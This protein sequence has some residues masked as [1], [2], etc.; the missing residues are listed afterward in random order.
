LP[1]RAQPKSGDP[2]R[3]IRALP[4]AS[5]TGASGNASTALMGFEGTVPGAV[6]RIKRGEELRARLVNGLAE[7]T[8]I[9]W[10]GVRVP[11]G[12]DGVPPLTQQPVEP[13]ASFDYTFRPRDAG[14]FWYRAHSL[15]QVGR[16]LYGALIIEES[17]N[18]DVDRDLVLVLGEPIATQS[19][20]K[21]PVLVNGSVSPEMAVQV[22]DRLRLRLINAAVARGFALKLQ[23]LIP[24]VAAIDGQPV[25]PFLPH[26]GRVV[27]A[28]GGR[29]DLF[30]DIAG[31][32]GAALMLAG[33]RDE[34]PIARLVYDG[35]RQPRSRR[36]QP[37]PALPS[38]PLPARID[39]KSALRAELVLAHASPIDLP[40]AP[41]FTVNRG[42]PVSL[43]IQKPSG[44]PHV[45]HL[46]GHHF[47]LLDRLDDGWKPY[48]LD[49][50]VIGEA[51]ERIAF[52]ADN[53]GR[54]LI[55]WHMLERPNAGA[56][57]WFAVT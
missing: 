26:E 53:P 17:E 28:P 24:W 50:L 14:T 37:P 16:G 27:L 30:A 46:H 20:S 44:G 18:V 11:N 3:V 8:S 34:Q 49:K 43:G 21:A 25:D 42:R 41:M 1:T 55:E 9:H 10:H 38:N 40:R 7:P 57:T 52:V 13:G 47:R 22:G 36:Q 35:T 29:I 12:M 56:A 2:A 33:M 15:E 45:V 6:L 31:D 51:G 54:W 32:R 4:G 5:F 23:G 39:L 48:W 19:P